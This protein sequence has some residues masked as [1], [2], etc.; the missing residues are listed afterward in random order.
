MWNSKPINVTAGGK[1]GNYKPAVATD[2]MCKVISR[3]I[4][5]VKY[6]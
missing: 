6:D 2:N 4:G 5:I 1:Y 3:R